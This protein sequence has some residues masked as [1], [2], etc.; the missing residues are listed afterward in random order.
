MKTKS[1][2]SPTLSKEAT[3][4]SAEKATLSSPNQLMLSLL[5]PPKP[6]LVLKHL[7]RHRLPKHLRHLK[8]LR[9]LR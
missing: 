4:S 6:L 3:T 1:M 8:Q 5:Q 2:E 9:D 7:R